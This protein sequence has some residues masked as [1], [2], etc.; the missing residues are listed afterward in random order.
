MPKNVFP[1][2]GLTLLHKYYDFIRIAIQNNRAKSCIPKFD[3][4]VRKT[5]ATYVNV[6]MYPATLEM[7]LICVIDTFNL[8]LFELA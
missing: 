5:G 4:L 3:C 7:N 6:C 8:L 2:V 1:W